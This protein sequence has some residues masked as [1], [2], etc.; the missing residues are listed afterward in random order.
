VLSVNEMALNLF[1]ELA[2]YPEEFNAVF[3]QLD[4]GAR[5]VDC[6]VSTRGG[7]RAGEMFTEICMGGLA[8]TTTT[9]G[10]I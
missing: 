4:N 8:E 5:I 6:G 9:M 2:E 7:Y 1:E 10:K 3:H